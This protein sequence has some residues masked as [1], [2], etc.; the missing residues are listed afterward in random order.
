MSKS[1]LFSGEIKRLKNP[2]A[3]K[4]DRTFSITDVNGRDR[5]LIEKVYIAMDT[6]ADQPEWEKYWVE[7][8]LSE[9]TIHTLNRKFIHN[10]KEWTYGN[11]HEEVCLD[12]PATNKFV[13][14]ALDSVKA[15]LTRQSKLLS[16]ISPDNI[17]YLIER[18]SAQGA[19]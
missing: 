17:R 3:N 14:L 19:F 10:G 13:T 2:Q 9:P 18:F 8:G 1:N 12:V 11:P 6:I 5:N 16:A 7:K 4:V 15:E